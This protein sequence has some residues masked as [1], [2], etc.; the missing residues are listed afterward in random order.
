MNSV[1]KRWFNV[2]AGDSTDP[3]KE[4]EEE[5][6]E[7]DQ[8]TEGNEDLQ[9]VMRRSFGSDSKA[10]KQKPPL[11]LPAIRIKRSNSV[12]K[13]LEIRTDD[14]VTPSEQTKGKPT[15]HFLVL[16]ELFPPSHLRQ[17]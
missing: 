6:K 2:I 4:E 17:M 14:V 8:P 9:D 5:Q 13:P 10:M 7:A 12:I 15:Q 1:P 16:S 3:P 11:P